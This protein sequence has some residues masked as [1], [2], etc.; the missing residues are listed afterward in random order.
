MYAL[1][2][3]PS[4]TRMVS[5]AWMLHALPHPCHTFG[6]MFHSD[7]AQRVPQPAIERRQRPRDTDDLALIKEPDLNRSLEATR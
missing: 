4:V 7:G 1:L 2:F 5:N 6:C 3:S